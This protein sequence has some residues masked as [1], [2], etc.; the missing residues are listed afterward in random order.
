MINVNAALRFAGLQSYEGVCSVAKDNHW[1]DA[2]FADEEIDM[3]VSEN[4]VYP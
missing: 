4:V 3:G 2:D 1:N